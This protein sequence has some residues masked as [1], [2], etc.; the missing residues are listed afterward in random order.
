MPLTHTKQLLTSNSS[1]YQ[2][3]VFFGLS[4]G[5]FFHQQHVRVWQAAISLSPLSSD[6]YQPLLW[7]QP[8]FVYK[9]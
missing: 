3:A 6:F 2:K 1:N 9:R 8:A 7:P 5:V 4:H